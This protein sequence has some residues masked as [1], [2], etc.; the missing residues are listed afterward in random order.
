MD[1]THG[2]R[3]H[4][5][6]TWKK[7]A[8]KWTH[9]VPSRVVQLTGQLHMRPC[10]PHV[11]DPPA[12]H[13][14]LHLGNSNRPPPGPNLSPP[15]APL[16]ASSYDEPSQIR[17]APSHALLHVAEFPTPEPAWCPSTP[18]AGPRGPHAARPC[19]QGT[20]SQTATRLAL[21]PRPS[22]C[23]NVT[24]STRP[25]PTTASKAAGPTRALPYSPCGT[26]TP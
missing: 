23:P 3:E 22:L 18:T 2:D 9:V 15:H 25:V 26:D 1:V 4:C 16:S 14:H 6:F 8:C 5:I 13:C 17:I 10:S 7:S 21:S 20:L 12:R 11:D 19:G 24:Y